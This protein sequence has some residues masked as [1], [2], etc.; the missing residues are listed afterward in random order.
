[1]DKEKGLSASKP[2]GDLLVT[3][4]KDGGGVRPKENERRR[5]RDVRKDGRKEEVGAARH[6]LKESCRR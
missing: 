3:S 4:N 1:M 6:L 2:E 5:E